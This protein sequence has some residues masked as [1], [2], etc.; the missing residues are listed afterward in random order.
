MKAGLLGIGRKRIAPTV[1]LDYIKTLRIL[2]DPVLR[3]EQKNER[4]KAEVTDTA[5][6][7]Y[8]NIRGRAWAFFTKDT[9]LGM[10]VSKDF[11]HLTGHHP[12]GLTYIAADLAYR[13]VGI[14]SPDFL[15]DLQGQRQRIPNQ[16]PG[17]NLEQL[18]TSIANFN[19]HEVGRDE[20]LTD[21]LGFLMHQ[22]YLSDDEAFFIATGLRVEDIRR[23]GNRGSGRRGQN[24][25]SSSPTNVPPGRTSVQPPQS[26]QQQ[27][28]QAP[29]QQA[30]QTP[31]P[32]QPQRA[33]QTPQ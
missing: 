14:D 5:E 3:E 19:M 25:R 10:R 15:S 21:A 1:T 2:Q 27:P 33:P 22:Q 29:S 9:P 11:A 16:N 28:Q 32:Q 23:A 17:L 6:E 4:I 12:P 7:R 13:A 24:Q 8:T 20:S 30:T 18:F 26:P 31:P